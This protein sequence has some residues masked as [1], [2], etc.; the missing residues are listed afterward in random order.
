MSD[1][2]RDFVVI[3]Q[4]WCLASV[5]NQRKSNGGKNKEEMII[6]MDCLGDEFEP[7]YEYRKGKK[8]DYLGKREM[9]PHFNHCTETTKLAIV[10]AQD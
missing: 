6:E 9:S 10:Y 8:P 5:K 4:P 2:Y 7:L 3:P 1:P